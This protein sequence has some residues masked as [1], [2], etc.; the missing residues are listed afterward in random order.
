MENEFVTLFEMLAKTKVDFVIIG[1]FA[2][3]IHGCSLS[4]QDIDVC[5]DFSPENLLKLQEAVADLNPVHRMTPKKLKL[6]LTPEKCK[7]LKNLYLDTDLGQLDCISYV[8][9]VGDFKKVKQSSRTII[10]DNVEYLVLDIDALIDSKKAL[11]REK[12][13]ITINQLKSIKK[14]QSENKES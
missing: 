7:N 10:V 14:N 4:T 3:I 5:C 11:N 6:E 1:G 8:T 2:G 13:R 9:G 12:D